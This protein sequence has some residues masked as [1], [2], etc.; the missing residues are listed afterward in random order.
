MQLKKHYIWIDADALA[1]HDEA[2]SLIGNRAEPEWAL[3]DEPSSH[4]DDLRVPG[5]PLEPEP[6]EFHVVR[7]A[8]TTHRARASTD[9]DGQ[10]LKRIGGRVLKTTT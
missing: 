1:L 7:I 4:S 5:G 3:L 2:V 9:L 10:H 8:G 6:H